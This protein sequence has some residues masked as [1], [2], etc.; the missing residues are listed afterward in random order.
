MIVAPNYIDAWNSKGVALANLGKQEDA[1][2]FF[3]PRLQGSGIR[4]LC[5]I[6]AW[7]SLENR[8]MRREQEAALVCASIAIVR[9]NVEAKQEACHLSHKWACEY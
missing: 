2:R 4:Q 5:R 7:F 6:S 3:F 8:F 1:H 9:I